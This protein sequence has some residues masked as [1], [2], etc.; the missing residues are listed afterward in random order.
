MKRFVNSVRNL[1]EWTSFWSWYY[2]LKRP[3]SRAE[4]LEIRLRGGLVARVPGALMSA[5]DEVFLREVYGRALSPPLGPAPVVIDIGANAGFFALQVFARYRDARVVALEPLPAHVALL[6]RQLEL[7]PGL[8]FTVDPRAVCARAGTVEIRFDSRHGL[9]VAASLFPRAD[10][11]GSLTVEATTLVDLY[12]TH[13]IGRCHLLKMDCEGAEYEILHHC[14]D[15][16]FAATD[17]IVLEA[18]DWVRD[19]GTIH[20]LARL[21][22]G[23][24]YRVRNHK[25]EILTCK[26]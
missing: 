20:D 5:F 15:D 11:D 24:G 7:N 18:H 21:L 6:R 2:A 19:Y 13:G 1:S 26:R 17:R 14:P 9:S 23:K 4:E 25:D 10:A 12:A 16:V 8:D 3:G 22:Q